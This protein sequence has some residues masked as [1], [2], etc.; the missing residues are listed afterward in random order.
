MIL[1]ADPSTQNFV[2]AP[3][4]R[5]S[6]LFSHASRRRC[7]RANSAEKNINAAQMLIPLTYLGAWLDGNLVVPRN[8]PHWPMRLIMTMEIPRR[9]SLPWLSEIQ[10][11]SL[12]APFLRSLQFTY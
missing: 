4:F 2:T 3:Y 11:V 9:L 1:S 7:A 12:E 10:A 5:S 8:G 6:L